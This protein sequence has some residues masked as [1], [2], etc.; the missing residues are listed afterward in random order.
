MILKLK[1]Y[2]VFIIKKSKWIFPLIT[3]NYLS[4]AA[5]NLR[6]KN[7]KILQLYIELLRHF[8]VITKN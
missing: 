1:G 2:P 4:L 3:L 8:L 5:T 6:S 7:F